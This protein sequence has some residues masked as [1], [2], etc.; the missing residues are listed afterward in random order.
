[1]GGGQAF[2]ENLFRPRFL[3]HERAHKENTLHQL[4]AP[5]EG[6]LP[7]PAL[8]RSVQPSCENM[9]LALSERD[10]I[11]EPVEKC[12]VLLTAAAVAQKLRL[13]SLAVS[14]VQDAKLVCQRHW[15]RVQHSQ[16]S[17]HGIRGC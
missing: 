10:I 7:I 13:R 4:V 1:M 6:H 16:R 14:H 3:G 9:R 11:A 17:F 12:L 2:V 15:R 5:E 8:P